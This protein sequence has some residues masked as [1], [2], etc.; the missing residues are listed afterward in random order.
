MS[1]AIQ[2][3]FDDIAH[4]YDFLNHFLSI[5]RDKSW[6]RKAVA[7]FSPH[8]KD[9]TLDL[10]AGTLDMTIEFV[11]QHG[12]KQIYASDF[13][14]NMLNLGKEKIKDFDN[15]F[16]DCSD[17]MNLPFGDNTFDGAMC[18][19]G[20]R[21]LPDTEKGVVEV[22]RVL[23]KGSK[24]V[25]LDFF[26]PASLFVKTFNALYEKTVIPVVGRLVSKDKRAYSYLPES[27]KRFSKSN[28]FMEMMKANGFES[29]KE[30]TCSFG[31]VSIISGVKK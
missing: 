17:S 4:R 20:V 10:C 11:N 16:L 14:I 13:S 28:E 9:K 24:F 15:I 22:R 23:K 12:N 7:L 21:N 29:V 27:R 2:E 30:Q 25:V 6:R 19:F 26:K 5:N 1:S 3:M 18:A 8:S 31:I